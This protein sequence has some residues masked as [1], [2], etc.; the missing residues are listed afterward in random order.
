MRCFPRAEQLLFR[1]LSIFRSGFSLAAAEAVC[2]GNG[3]SHPQQIL[4]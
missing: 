2:A 4:R 1:R 3:L